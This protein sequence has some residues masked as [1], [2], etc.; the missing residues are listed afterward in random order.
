MAWRA[1]TR[2]QP[3]ICIGTRNQFRGNTRKLQSINLAVERTGCQ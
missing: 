3:T 2:H 1:H